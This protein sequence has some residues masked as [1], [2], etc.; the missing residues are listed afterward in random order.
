MRKKSAFQETTWVY[1]QLGRWH[2]PFIMY[3]VAMEWREMRYICNTYCHCPI[4]NQLSSYRP[5]ELK[6][7]TTVW[8]KLSSRLKPVNSALTHILG[9]FLYTKL[10]FLDMSSYQ[11]RWGLEGW[12]LPTDDDTERQEGLQCMS[13][14]RE[15]PVFLVSGG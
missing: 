12:S 13:R 14:K 9:H 15:Y 11:L 3:D 10:T 6:S 2:S 4:I 1:C 7:R 5:F 8:S